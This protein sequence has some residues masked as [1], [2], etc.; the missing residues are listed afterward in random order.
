MAILSRCTSQPIVIPPENESSARAGSD[1]SECDV[2]THYSY[3]PKDCFLQQ[4][5]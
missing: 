2:T 5:L 4:V 3:E 1:F